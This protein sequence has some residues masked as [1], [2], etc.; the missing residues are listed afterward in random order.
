MLPG[1][2]EAE[3]DDIALR[4][5]TMGRKPMAPRN[6]RTTRI[7]SSVVSPV[8]TNHAAK[9]SVF[10]N[11]RNAGNLKTGSPGSDKAEGDRMVAL[12]PDLKAHHRYLR[13]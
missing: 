7:P 1:S 4:K 2:D 5:A 3:G 13:P 6:D 12:L 11:S 8:T 10:V 9:G